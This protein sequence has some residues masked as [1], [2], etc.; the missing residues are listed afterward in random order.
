MTRKAEGIASRRDVEK[1]TNKVKWTSPMFLY[2][3]AEGQ[4]RVMAEI[5]VSERRYT[6]ERERKRDR[7]RRMCPFVLRH[8]INNPGHVTQIFPIRRKTSLFFF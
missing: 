2:P 7:M 5:P 6:R 8:I 3:C 1:K 4:R